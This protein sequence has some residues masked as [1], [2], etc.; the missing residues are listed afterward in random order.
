MPDLES[1]RCRPRAEGPRQRCCLPNCLGFRA[2]TITLLTADRPIP[3]R[4]QHGWVC[5]M[6]LG[7]FLQR[8]YDAVAQFLVEGH[9]CIR[10]GESRVPAEAGLARLYLPVGTRRQVGSRPVV[11]LREPL[12]L[13]FETPAD[14]AVVHLRR[15]V[16]LQLRRS[17]SMAAVVACQDMKLGSPI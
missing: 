4:A 8:L 15:Y 11:I 1:G 16:F 17:C 9:E 3:K 5:V 14:Q 13:V 2:A 6:P 12:E 7:H 10:F